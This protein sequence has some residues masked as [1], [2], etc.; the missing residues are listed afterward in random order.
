MLKL[1][2][3]SSFFAIEILTEVRYSRKETP[4]LFSKQMAEIEG[5]D[6]HGLRRFFQRDLLIVISNV[7]LGLCING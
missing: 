7:R 4:H 2:C 5:I 1:L 3:L 6:S